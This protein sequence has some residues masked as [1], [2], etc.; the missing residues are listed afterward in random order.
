MSKNNCHPKLLN[1]CFECIRKNRSRQGG[2]SIAENSKSRLD[3]QKKMSFESAY[4]CYMT[5]ILFPF[6]LT[7]S[8]FSDCLGVPRGEERINRKCGN[9]RVNIPLMPCSDGISV[10]MN[11]LHFPLASV[12]I[13]IRRKA[14][15]L[16]IWYNLCFIDWNEGGVV[17]WNIRISSISE[18]P[19]RSWMRQKTRHFY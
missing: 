5:A 2:K 16:W 6:P 7:A 12:I 9:D 11:S 1:S 10:S 3:W 15:I 14:D 18:N 4:F 13:K 19:C 17:R 8:A